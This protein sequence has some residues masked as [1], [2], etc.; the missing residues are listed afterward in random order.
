MWIDYE[1]QWR[2]KR[3]SLEAEARKM[4]MKALKAEIEELQHE[5]QWSGLYGKEMTR[6]S[7]L[8]KEYHRRTG[9]HFS[10]PRRVYA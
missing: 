5:N 1:K 9:K 6:Y 8:K 7:V 2:E 10:V 4:K 3:E